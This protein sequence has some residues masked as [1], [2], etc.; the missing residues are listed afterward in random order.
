MV[1]L[2]HYFLF[3]FV[4]RW[5]YPPTSLVICKRFAFLLS[6]PTGEEQP[7]ANPPDNIV[8]IQKVDPFARKPY[9]V[10]NTQKESNKIEKDNVFLDPTPEQINKVVHRMSTASN[11]D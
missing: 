3:C 8:L 7:W 5:G 1:E 2:L 6:L 11:K 4:L 10:E 9:T